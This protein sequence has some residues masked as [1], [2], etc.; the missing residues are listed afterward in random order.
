MT[1]ATSSRLFRGMKS[2][3]LRETVAPLLHQRAGLHGGACFSSAL[4][5]KKK[6]GRMTALRPRNTDAGMRRSSFAAAPARER[7]QRPTAGPEVHVE[8]EE[9]RR[10]HVADG[11]V[12]QQ[13]HGEVRAAVCRNSS[14]VRRP[15]QVVC[16]HEAQQLLLLFQRRVDD[17]DQRT[18]CERVC[19]P[20]RSS[21]RAL[22][23]GTPGGWGCV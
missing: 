16:G 11:G 4:R 5:S 2:I 9:V 23:A 1:Q 7:E 8:D 22:V 13:V 21:R 17:D 18:T 10:R 14:S 3:A 15:R 6:P 12:A 20:T 19:S